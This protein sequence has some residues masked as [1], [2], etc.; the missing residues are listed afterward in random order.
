MTNFP[1]QERPLVDLYRDPEPDD[2]L[3]IDD[4]I[5]RT[6][7]DIAMGEAPSNVMGVLLANRDRGVPT[8]EIAVRL[9]KTQPQILGELATLEVAGWAVRFQD[10]NREKYIIRGAVRS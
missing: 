5:A 7:S 3:S 10:N 6:I 1:S 8:A 9:G 4:Q 2:V